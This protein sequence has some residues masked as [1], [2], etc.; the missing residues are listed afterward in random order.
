MSTPAAALTEPARLPSVEEVRK[1]DDR[2]G[3]VL[4]DLDW[5]TTTLEQLTGDELPA[6]DYLFMRKEGISWPDRPVGF[7]PAAY[8]AL[9]R[10]WLELDEGA[11]LIKE[12]A[13]QLRASLNAYRVFV[14]DGTDRREVRCPARLQDRSSF[15]KGK[16]GRRTCSASTPT[17]NGGYVTLDGVGIRSRTRWSSS[18]TSSPTF[19]GA[20]ASAAGP[21]VGGGG[22]GG[23]ELP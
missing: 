3:S 22:S 20:M 15:A 6:Q 10:S 12:Y 2:L 14:I 9:V 17:G 7:D 18:R 13:A 5:F 23:P 16:R 1:T 11:D 8:A 4:S 19:A 21:A